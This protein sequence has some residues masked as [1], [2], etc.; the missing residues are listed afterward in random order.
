MTRFEVRP[1]FSLNVEL[2]GSGPTL[3]L[4]H[5]F[6]GSAASWGRFG[7]LLGRSFR[8]VAID[9]VGH[10]R[11]DAPADV[12]DY[13]MEQVSADLAAAARHAGVAQAPWLGY[14]MG[15]RAAL[16]LAC[17][18]PGVVSALVTI[19][20]SPGLETE[21]ERAERRRADEE[22]ADRIERHGIEAFVDYWESLPLWASQQSLP[23]DVRAA[24][25]RVRLANRPTGL[26]NS[27]RGMG[28][29][30]QPSFWEHLPSLDLPFLA[31]AGELDRKYVEIARRMVQLAPRGTASAIPGV[32]HAA[33]L[34]APGAVVDAVSRFLTDVAEPQLEARP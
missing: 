9:I 5:G 23:S 30:A 18:V 34:E 19:G 32:G 21:N 15:G 8:C 16:A 28:A 3:V 29:G 6:T 22:L 24:Q 4:L 2:W 26:A 27:L 33:Q 25:R 12:A 14:S 7:E 11:S 31:L 10:G 13:R 17:L 20:A 1:G